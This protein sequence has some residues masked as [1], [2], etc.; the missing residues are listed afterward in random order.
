VPTYTLRPNA[1][2]TSQWTV[3][4]PATAWEAL[5]EAITQPTTPSPL[6]DRI[7]TGTLNQVTEVAL[8]TTTLAGGETVDSVTVWVFSDRSGGTTVQGTAQL[9][10][11]ATAKGSTVNLG[12]PA[13]GS[14]KSVVYTGSLTQGELDDLRIR[15]VCTTGAVANVRAMRAYAEVATTTSAT[16]VEGPVLDLRR[17]SRS[18]GISRAPRQPFQRQLRSEG[19]TPARVIPVVL[20]RSRRRLDPAPLTGRS[21]T[22]L[23]TPAQ[24]ST[25][26]FSMLSGTRALPPMVG[27]L[28]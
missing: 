15:F 4:G 6:T 8:D 14:W 23:G 26:E 5:D 17:R 24:K 13:T 3:S 27:F 22:S 1:D 10:T 7:V 25:A 20:P 12:S 2:V 28:I 9:F 21:S 11:G 19:S 18:S 16:P